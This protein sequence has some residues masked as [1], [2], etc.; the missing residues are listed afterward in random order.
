MFGKHQTKEH[1]TQEKIFKEQKFFKTVI[2]NFFE[3]SPLFC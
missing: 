3:V 1:Q 2:I